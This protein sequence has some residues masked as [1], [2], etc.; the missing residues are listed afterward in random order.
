MPKTLPV[1]KLV[2]YAAA[3]TAGV[4]LSRLTK[5]DWTTGIVLTVAVVALFAW[6]LLTQRRPRH[7]RR[8]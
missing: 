2:A 1:N 7:K 5:G 6:Y 4:A 3:I 8:Y